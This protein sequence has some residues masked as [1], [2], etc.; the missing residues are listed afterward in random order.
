MTAHY[1]SQIAALKCYNGTEHI[2]AELIKFFYQNRIVIKNTLFYTPKLNGK[3]ERLNKT[4]L[5]K[6]RVMILEAKLKKSKW[7]EAIQ[8]ARYLTNRSSTRCIEN[9]TS[10]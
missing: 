4:L 2:S 6:A 9:T 10:A 5:V 3:A 7:G 8:Y 1:S